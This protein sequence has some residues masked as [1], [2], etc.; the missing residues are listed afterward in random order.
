MP[1]DFGAECRKFRE[2]QAWRA[3]KPS[4]NSIEDAASQKCKK[5]VERS[6]DG[7]AVALA[8]AKTTRRLSISQPLIAVSAD[9]REL[10]NRTWHAAPQQYLEAAV[11][12]AGVFPLIV[13][14]FGERLDLDQL[15]FA[16]A[17]Q[18][19]THTV[20]RAYDYGSAASATIG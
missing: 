11:S 8:I 19:A 17:R 7:R 2:S 14:R 5:I 6:D 1:Q 20:T 3:L 4:L 9:L 16:V 18:L 10:N 13:P 12:G 15:L